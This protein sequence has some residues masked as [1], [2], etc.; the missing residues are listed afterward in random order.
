M[1]DGASR[2][3]TSII[4]EFAQTLG[5]ENFY[6][7]GEITGMN[8]ALDIDDVQDKIE[9]LIKGQH[10]RASFMNGRDG[11]WGSVATRYTSARLRRPVYPPLRSGTPP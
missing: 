11:R 9:Y 5:K 2:L 3:F 8:A 1:D 10:Q 6:L 7:I 4:H